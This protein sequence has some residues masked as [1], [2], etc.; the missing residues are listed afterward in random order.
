MQGPLGIGGSVSQ[1]LMI[2]HI[3]ASKCQMLRSRP[4]HWVRSRS[5]VG[6]R[7]TRL[8][9]WPAL[10]WS[11][12][13][14]QFRE[15]L[16]VPAWRE[17][18]GF[19]AALAKVAAITPQTAV[20]LPSVEKPRRRRQADANAGIGP[21]ARMLESITQRGRRSAP[22]LRPAVRPHSRR[23]GRRPASRFCRRHSR[24]PLARQE[25]PPRALRRHPQ[26]SRR[27]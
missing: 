18:A 25:C 4:K 27:P 26:R 3:G 22:R 11:L 9:S 14:P 24:P 2:A 20:G 16:R 7:P 23:S 12:R 15:I 13:W 19:A 6:T 8:R 1:V 17:E 10:H 21:L 5:R